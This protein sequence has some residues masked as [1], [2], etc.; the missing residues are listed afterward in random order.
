MVIFLFD[1]ALNKVMIEPTTISIYRE[2]YSCR[3][4]DIH[5][6]LFKR[7]FKCSYREQSN[8]LVSLQ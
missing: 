3:K 2:W 8:L 7:R 4:C 1:N 6:Y 5:L